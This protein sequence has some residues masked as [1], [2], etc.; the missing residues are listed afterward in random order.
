M[1]QAL[2]AHFG[3]A[4]LLRIELAETESVTPAATAQRARE[5]LQ[6]KAVAAIEQDGFV[7]DVIEMFDA[8]LVESSI[9]PI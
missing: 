2:S 4:L 6:D 7:R 1:Q 3:R 5:E 9:K 8:Q